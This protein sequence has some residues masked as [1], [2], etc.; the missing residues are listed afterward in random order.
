MK[1][2][3]ATKFH[4]KSGENPGPPA[5]PPSIAKCTELTQQETAEPEE[6]LQQAIYTLTTHFLIVS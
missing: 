6:S 4:R 5:D 2:T 1:F 3:E